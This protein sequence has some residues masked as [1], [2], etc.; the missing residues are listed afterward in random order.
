M[1]G[2]KE[3][4]FHSKFSRMEKL[5][6]YLETHMKE[7][8]D[9]FAPYI[10]YYQDLKSQ[11]D[12]LYK[13]DT[14]G[15]AK[16]LNAEDIDDLKTK[17]Q[18]AVSMLQYQQSMMH[19]WAASKNISQ[20]IIEKTNTYF[21]D[22]NGLINR[23]INV[24]NSLDVRDNISLPV[25]VYKNSYELDHNM[26]DKD[27][28]FA[29]YYRIMKTSSVSEDDLLDKYRKSS[30]EKI[31]NDCKKRLEKN[32]RLYEYVTMPDNAIYAINTGDTNIIS[33]YL[34][35]H[36]DNLT[37]SQRT[38][39][40]KQIQ[41]VT[42]AKGIQQNAENTMSNGEELGTKP[43]VFKPSG[44]S[45]PDACE[46]DI[47]LPAFQTSSQGC[48]SCGAQM[49]IHSRG[50]MEVT[51]EHVRDFRTD[52][53][54]QDID[55]DR[56]LIN[57][58]YNTD[59]GNNFMNMCDSV[60]AFAPN[61]MVHELTIQQYLRPEE[62][63]GIHPSD[64]L[65]NSIDVVKKTIKHA[66]TVDHSPLV[67]RMPGHYVTIIGIDG[68]T[69]KYKDSSSRPLSSPNETLTGSLKEILTDLL[70]N[71]DAAKRTAVELSW[72]S[73][74]KLSK[75]GKNIHGIP[76]K[77]TQMNE[78]G[79]LTLPPEKI[80][81]QANEVNRTGINKNGIRIYRTGGDEDNL[82][83]KNDKSVY[84]DGG[85]LKIEKVYIPTKL[86]ATY[87]KKMAEN[88]T[89]DE[90]AEL[91][92]T[93]REFWGVDH[94]KEIVRPD[95]ENNIV[96]DNNA[97]H[98]ADNV[99]QPVQNDILDNNLIELPHYSLS[100]ISDTMK[101][102]ADELDSHKIN[103][104]IAQYDSYNNLSTQLQ[105]IQNLA[106]Q[107]KRSAIRND[108]EF[109]PD[110]MR[111][112]IDL[113][114]RAIETSQK[115]LNSKDRDIK[116]NPYQ[117]VDP[118]KLEREQPRI[119]SVIE[120][121][122]KLMDI[123]N[124]LTGN[125]EPDIYIFEK[126]NIINN[127]KA[128]LI[129]GAINKK[130]QQED[131]YKNRI[132]EPDRVKEQLERV[133]AIMGI[134]PELLD[135]FDSRKVFKKEMVNGQKVSVFRKIKSV[136]KPFKAIGS[137]NNNDVLSSKDFAALSFAAST[138]KEVY[139]KIDA[140][141]IKFDDNALHNEDTRY[142]LN[143]HKLIYN[144]SSKIDYPLSFY[145]DNINDSKD[146]AE[147]ALRSYENGNK[148]PLAQLITHGIKFFCRVSLNNYY[149]GKVDLMVLSEM[150]QRMS[151]MLD[152]D[153][154]LMKLA[155]SNGLTGKELYHIRSLDTVG[156]IYDN[157]LNR[158]D[159]IMQKA[160]EDPGENPNWTDEQKLE[161][162]TD[163]L[164]GIRYIENTST[165]D[166]SVSVNPDY[167]KEIKERDINARN[168]SANALDK[169]NVEIRNA[170]ESTYN[171]NEGYEDLLIQYNNKIND[172]K[173][174]PDEQ[175]KHEALE[176]ANK[177]F[178]DELQKFLS[179]QAAKIKDYKEQLIEELNDEIIAEGINRGIDFNLP[180]NEPGKWRVA[181]EL[182]KK[183][184]EDWRNQLQ[185]RSDDI[186]ET[187]KTARNNGKKEAEI[188]NLVGESERELNEEILD[189]KDK[190]ITFHNHEKAATG[191][192]K[193]I[194]LCNDV[195]RLIQGGGTLQYYND[196]T[197]DLIGEK[198]RKSDDMLQRMSEPGMYSRERRRIREYLKGT[199]AYKLS[200]G[201]FYSK[202]D[203]Y[204]AADPPEF[205]MH[206]ERTDTVTN[207]LTKYEKLNPIQKQT[208]A[209][210]YAEI[211][212]VRQPGVQNQVQ[213]SARKD[214]KDIQNRN[215]IK[216]F[217]KNSLRFIKAVERT[218]GKGKSDSKPSSLM[219]DVLNG[220]KGFTPDMSIGE[221]S[222]RLDTL[223]KS[224][225]KYIEKRGYPS[226]TDRVERIE[227]L[228]EL[229]TEIYK[230]KKE[231][232][233]IK[234]GKGGMMHS[235]Q[236]GNETKGNKMTAD[237]L[238]KNL[239]AI[240]YSILNKRE[241]GLLNMGQFDPN[242]DYPRPDDEPLPPEPSPELRNMMNAMREWYSL[243]EPGPDG[244]GKMISFDK[245]KAAVEKVNTT[246]TIWLSSNKLGDT[247]FS[248]SRYEYVRTVRDNA[249]NTLM[250]IRKMQPYMD[251][252]LPEGR[253][254]S[255][256]VFD[257][258]KSMPEPYNKIEAITT[259]RSEMLYD[260]PIVDKW[261]EAKHQLKR[262]NNIIQKMTDKGD[263]L[264]AKAMSHSFNVSF[265]RIYRFPLSK[266]DPSRKTDVK[267]K[268]RIN[269]MAYDAAIQIFSHK[270][271]QSDEWADIASKYT[272]DEFNEAFEEL[273]KELSKTNAFRNIVDE[274]VLFNI[275][276]RLM[277]EAKR[278]GAEKTI[279]SIISKENFERIIKNQREAQRIKNAQQANNQ[280]H[281][282]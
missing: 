191:I 60:L 38:K 197:K 71:K 10:H 57:E 141:Q 4:Q 265:Q 187:K 16:R 128:D 70:I 72:V 178:R 195:K 32:P 93:D 147:K 194:D 201:E 225:N 152:R 179:K 137:D 140:K 114:S 55:A 68:D 209:G 37:L 91:E 107:G 206:T 29:E 162:Y 220:L 129:N 42:L 86:N 174:V 22:V 171:V 170:L 106:E 144:F 94:S 5:N 87:L 123:R 215:M 73:D 1:P 280:G 154:E 67:F 212:E 105:Q 150:G 102:L 92:M 116:E 241:S 130:K 17:Y 173:K 148:A 23:D 238:K 229:N 95:V 227:Y 247:E 216:A 83:N 35:Q 213:N 169:F 7:F 41:A 188:N 12:S 59:H 251:V 182:K 223:Q 274:S 30:P 56:F 109:G 276:N 124:S 281:A 232:D 253:L 192:F 203:K 279:D 207:M 219:Q 268:E 200:P 260:N 258:V 275:D 269:I 98:V 190:Y 99:V 88:R 248:I 155:V 184:M 85:I 217:S 165:I 76:S 161:N 211:A 270:M 110:Q 252:M 26:Q 262:E 204:V 177:E 47:S 61:S 277:K 63:A 254:G 34:N 21:N 164:M 250:S 149:S 186:D 159:F 50:N 14:K 256:N 133:D 62:K 237:D 65:E 111:S 222:K 115:Y 242:M 54:T 230:T 257:T 136:K 78:D 6:R 118:D 138:T 255:L 8:Y 259:E 2:F 122:D 74:I 135:E 81:F 145:V 126:E 168:I 13:L 157:Y 19:D 80:M 44:S 228:H 278:L 282:L 224:V 97:V 249:Q 77:Y 139:S 208:L 112:L 199:G 261:N 246:A 166:Y 146:F 84:S 271:D 18:L 79:S 104:Y 172:S 24:V 132:S 263:A 193:C 108:G 20:N 27:P 53:T 264:R 96:N 272:S 45:D 205:H 103:A 214:R 180:E 244:K 48:W 117:K 181:V 64:Y 39:L 143:A 235:I 82:L 160:S 231:I 89:A 240:T 221:F 131:S 266:V 33:D 11:M 210:K 125:K 267:L 273:S 153:P 121:L 31:L 185:K 58:Q 75:D 36:E 49:L 127:Y 243:G 40:E 119:R 245:L 69:I 43:R 9:N 167:I 183:H 234:N 51:Q 90:E 142:K 158:Y 236:L 233:S 176:E 189:F 239:L 28:K 52:L 198:Y 15:N 163:Y 151:A 101:S 226:K 175:L 120:S 202:M 218:Y 3:L 113:V 25:A 196:R 156:K 46:L 134:Q 100:D 66:I